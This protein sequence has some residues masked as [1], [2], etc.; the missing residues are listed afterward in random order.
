VNDFKN[1]APAIKDQLPEYF[2]EK[3]VLEL[4]HLEQGEVVDEVVL[5][6]VVEE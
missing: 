5:E 6:V 1:L 4:V 2:T 3:A